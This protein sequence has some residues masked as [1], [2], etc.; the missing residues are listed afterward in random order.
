MGGGE[1]GLIVRNTGFL[2]LEVLK[3]NSAPKEQGDD[4]LKERTESPG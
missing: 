1:M 3:E 4:R 2:S